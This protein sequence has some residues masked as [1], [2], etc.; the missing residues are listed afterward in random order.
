MSVASVVNKEFKPVVKQ[1][2]S[3][4]TLYADDQ[5]A[6]IK[7][8]WTRE[9]LLLELVVCAFFYG[10]AK[11]LDKQSN[12]NIQQSRQGLID[13]II[14]TCHMPHSSAASRLDSIEDMA[15]QYG[16]I[17]NIVQQGSGDAEN[18]LTCEDSEN[19]RLHSLVEK[20]RGHTMRE[21]G[22]G[23]ACSKNEAQQKLLFLGLDE[24]MSRIYQRAKMLACLSCVLSIFALL[25]IYW[26]FNW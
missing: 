26:Q 9:N 24:S 5:L 25:F 3:I 7:P 22:I 19:D 18:W 13:L 4:L 10:A 21:Y 12:I 6:S 17:D 1:K 11:K 23:T 14:V 8:G 16:L 2:E 15:R 20:Y